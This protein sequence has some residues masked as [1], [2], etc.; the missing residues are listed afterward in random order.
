MD[1][2]IKNNLQSFKDWA[3]KDFFGIAAQA[4]GGKG[5]S[6][7]LITK[8][9][10]QTGVELAKD[11]QSQANASAFID[12]IAYAAQA[13]IDIC[14]EKGINPSQVS[15]PVNISWA[16]PFASDKDSLKLDQNFTQETDNEAMIYASNFPTEDSTV[17]HTKPFDIKG[18]ILERLSKVND[19]TYWVSGE[20]GKWIFQKSNLPTIKTNI[21]NDGNMVAI[22]SATQAGLKPD[23]VYLHTV[24]GGGGNL[25]I[26]ITDAKSKI[27]SVINT[28]AFGKDLKDIFTDKEIKDI[29]LVHGD[30]VDNNIERWTAGGNTNDPDAKKGIKASVR[31]LKG[32]VDKYKDNLDKKNPVN[33]EIKEF[34]EMNNLLKSISKNLKISDTQITN[35]TLMK[36][37]QPGEDLNARVSQAAQ[38][39]DELALALLKHQN[40]I[41]AQTIIRTLKKRNI[42]TSNI[43]QVSYH[44]S[45]IS[46]R[47]GVEA[48]KNHFI[49]VLN[50]GLKTNINDIVHHAPDMDG[51]IDLTVAELKRS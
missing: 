43:A 21:T 26:V 23:S 8:G 36:D 4:G 17:N 6:L 37:P 33:E 28:E 19:R 34:I 22:S 24:Q 7:K 27:V 14:Q 30:R 47:L 49:K 15:I 32:I 10:R 45:S 29:K 13:T 11:N 16:G 25:N 46:G 40:W 12:A 9:N 48:I 35:S 42:D 18:K 5:L 41:T 44:G 51:T 3:G 31:Y 2:S 38:K 20:Q 50:E 1:S 39:G